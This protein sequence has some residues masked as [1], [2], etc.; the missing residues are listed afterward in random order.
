MGTHHNGGIE[1][2]KGGNVS[3]PKAA[4]MSMGI[5]NNKK[6]MFR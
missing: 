1:H 2:R 4:T 5:G 6:P 3:N